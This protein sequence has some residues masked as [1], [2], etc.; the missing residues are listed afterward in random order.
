M[1][2]KV[3]FA[4]DLSE[5]STHVIE[6]IKDLKVYG[7][8]EI[9]LFHALGIKYLE[10]LRYS[11]VK[12][13]EPVLQ[14]QKAMLE[15]YGYSVTVHIANDGVS[16]ELWK[17]AK[18]ENVSMVVI[19]THGRS[20]AF[21]VSLG[22]TAHKIIHDISKPLLIVR[23]RSDDKAM[24]VCQAACIDIDKPLLFTTD[25]SD[26]AELAFTYVEKMAESGIKHVV[27][28]HVQDKTRIE[29]Y[30]K[31]KLNEFNTIDTE[32]LEMLKDR[33][34][35]KG[36]KNVDCILKYGIPVEE[37]IN[38]SRNRDYSLIIMGALGRSLVK[39]VF[40]GSVSWNVVRNA[41]QPVLLIPP[42]K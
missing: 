33:L 23:L 24:P 25:F 15:R 20:L 12:E 31:D 8:K 2:S 38:E 41:S 29:K 21:D 1:F 16:Y 3:L 6:C 26:T 10:D 36:V 22:G 11:L 42:L 9:I 28:M 13:A 19:G 4:S 30:L 5:A 40:I 17:F 39:D 14:K 7:T 32:R 27:L 18:Q 37:I 35:K 34:V